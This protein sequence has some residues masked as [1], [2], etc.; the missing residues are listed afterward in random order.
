MLN[1][2][3]FSV[4]SPIPQ[5]CSACLS[6]LSDPSSLTEKL[7]L[8]SVVRSAFKTHSTDSHI[9]ARP[10]APPW[11]R[12]SAR[13]P[14]TACVSRSAW[15]DCD[16]MMCASEA[17]VRCFSGK[18]CNFWSLLGIRISPPVKPVKLFKRDRWKLVVDTSGGSVSV[19][20]RRHTFQW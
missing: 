18:F 12:L 4:N 11:L 16:R 17:A 2:W 19:R 14:P 13:L 1:A 6:Q 7:S 20:K 3:T 9:S 5:I 8:S 10:P 15:Q